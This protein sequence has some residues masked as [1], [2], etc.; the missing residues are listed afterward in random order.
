MEA[1]SMI[2]GKSSCS[3]D[4]EAYY[5]G[6]LGGDAIVNILLGISNPGGKLRLLGIQ[7]LGLVKDAICTTWILHLV[8]D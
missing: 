3:I 5:P 8:T 1:R 7:I 6:Q 2:T 4:L